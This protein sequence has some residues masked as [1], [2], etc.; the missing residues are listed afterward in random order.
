MNG[1]S[2]GDAINDWGEG[3]EIE[4]CEVVSSMP[5][6]E[7]PSTDT[8]SKVMTNRYDVARQAKIGAVVYCPFCGKPGIKTT[9]NKAFCRGGNCKDRFWNTVNAKRRQRSR[10]FNKKGIKKLVTH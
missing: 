3:C 9:Y 7:N 2:E 10:A 6:M 5:H 1:Q 4:E 8:L